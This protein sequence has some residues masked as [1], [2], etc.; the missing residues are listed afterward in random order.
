MSGIVTKRV[1]LA[2]KVLLTGR[3]TSSKRDYSGEERPA[4]L[5]GCVHP[6]YYSGGFVV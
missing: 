3:K 4:C 2:I 6:G 5:F 1:A